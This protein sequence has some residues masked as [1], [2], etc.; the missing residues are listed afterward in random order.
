MSE[1]NLT[2]R[3]GAVT[4]TRITE[5][6]GPGG[7][8][9]YLPDATRE[10][11]REIDWLQPHFA[12][13]EGRLI[14]AIHALVIE[15]PDA[16]IVVDTCVGNDKQREVPA[17]NQLQT[18]FLDDMAEAGYG[19]DSID[20]VMCTHLHV[21]HVGWNTKLVDEVWIPTFANARYLFGRTE[22]D[23][24]AARGDDPRFGPVFS[25]SVKPVFDAGL[26]D[27][28][29]TDHQ[30]APGVRLTSTPGHTPGHVSVLI[31]SKGEQAFIT[32]DMLHHPCQMAHP[33]WGAVVDEDK[34]QAVQTRHDVFSRFAGTP[35]LVIGTH[36]A[37]PTAGRIVR[38]GDAYRL[39]VKAR[40]PKPNCGGDDA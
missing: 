21:D 9:R 16:R 18:S 32:G 38:D 10:R 1:H 35:T 15:T 7:L 27:L 28:V 11:V 24:W 3:V 13:D 22:Y 34:P 14:G 31:E 30:V 29:E 40:N 26:V 6:E 5:F 12:T 2:W 39:D 8:S 4:I 36:F 20:I 37:A 19:A 25:D 33:E 23:F 17:W